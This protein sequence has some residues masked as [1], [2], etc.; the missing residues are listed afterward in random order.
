MFVIYVNRYLTTPNKDK[1]QTLVVPKKIMQL[2]GSEIE[3]NS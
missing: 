2:N 1:L 3:F